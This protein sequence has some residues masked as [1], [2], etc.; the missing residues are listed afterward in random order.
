MVLW[1]LKVRTA[2]NFWFLISA[3]ASCLMRYCINTWTGRDR[4]VGVFYIR[5]SINE[6]QTVAAA[7]SRW[8]V[9]RG[10]NDPSWWGSPRLWWRAGWDNLSRHAL[11]MHGLWHN[12]VVITCC[13][14][15]EVRELITVPASRWTRGGGMSVLASFAARGRPLAKGSDER[16]GPRRWQSI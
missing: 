12:R 14:K 2:E 16:S 8:A 13:L 9:L 3:P 6:S 15:G 11:E 10:S 1:A 4:E 5:P 7:V